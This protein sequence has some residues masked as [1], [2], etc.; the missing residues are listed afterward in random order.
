VATLEEGIVAHLMADS[1]VTDLISTRLYPMVVPQDVSL[2]AVA[3][4]RISGPREPVHEGASGLARARM[5]FTVL[6]ST[7]E[8]GKD[9]AEALRGSMDGFSGTMGTVAV[10]AAFLENDVDAWGTVFDKA[11]VRQDYMFWYQE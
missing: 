11:V 4:Q 9:V 7:Y 8:G 5:Q 3:Y 2:P 10:N 6:G 1:D